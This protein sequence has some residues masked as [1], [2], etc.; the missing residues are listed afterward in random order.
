MDP[1]EA[2]L[3]RAVARRLR[4]RIGGVKVKTSVTL[5]PEL[6]AAIDRARDARD[7]AI[8]NANIDRLNEEALDAFEMQA[9]AL[10]DE[11]WSSDDGAGRR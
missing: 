10:G 4:G 7:I 1:D 3:V 11:F 2:G 9:N 5:S 8:I 6:R